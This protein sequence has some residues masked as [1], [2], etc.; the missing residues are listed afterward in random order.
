MKICF[1]DDCD[2]PVKTRNW[3]SAHY[4][5]FQRY[6]D[7][8]GRPKSK[9]LPKRKCSVETCVRNQVVHNLCPAHHCRVKTHGDVLAHIP[10]IDGTQPISPRRY[11]RLTHQG[12]PLADAEN[13]VAEHRYVLYE[14]IGNGWHACHWC[15]NKISWEISHPH[16]SALTADHLNHNRSDN[17][18]ENL[19]PACS[20]CN[21]TRWAWREVV[22][23]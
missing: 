14:S 6:G 13:R 16:A 15:G 9:K 5:R 18:L 20:P 23:G 7:P 3:C 10:I 22:C 1:I 19:V 17:R 2:K 4:H 12:H 21:S 8:L 11:R